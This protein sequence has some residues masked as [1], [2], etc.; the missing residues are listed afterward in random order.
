MSILKN[1]VSV[2]HGCLNCYY[3]TWGIENRRLKI[4]PIFIGFK[5]I[6]IKLLNISKGTILE[7]K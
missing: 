3:G 6:I 4:A 1:H 2:I 7:I 5:E